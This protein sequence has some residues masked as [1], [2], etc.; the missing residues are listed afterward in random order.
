MKTRNLLFS[1][2]VL[3]LCVSGSAVATKMNWGPTGALDAFP[4]FGDYLQDDGSAYGDRGNGH[5]YGWF[6]GAGD[7]DPQSQNRNR[8]NAS[9][10]DERYDTLNHMR[11]GDENFWQIEIPNGEYSVHFVAGDPNH[12]DQ[13]NDIE[14]I[15]GSMT[16]LVDDEGAGNNFDEFDFNITVDEGYLRLVP[17][18]A[19]NNQKVSHMTLTLVPEPGTIVLGVFGLLGLFGLARRRRR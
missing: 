2:L 11:K 8:N 15:G 10:P 16:V 14:F 7:P 19:A 4:E 12:T 13:E 18:A 1:A 5:T 17:V 3:S 9:S 6:N